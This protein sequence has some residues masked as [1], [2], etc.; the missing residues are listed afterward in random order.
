MGR[1]RKTENIS[2]E[3]WKGV[4]DKDDDAPSSET[5]LSLAFEV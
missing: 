4:L 3:W 5:I 1:W 2:F